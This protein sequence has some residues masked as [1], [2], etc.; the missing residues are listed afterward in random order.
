MGAVEPK[1]FLAA[2]KY[3]CVIS[4]IIAFAKSKAISDIVKIHVTMQTLSDQMQ[5]QYSLILKLKNSLQHVHN[6]FKLFKI[7]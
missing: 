6:N 2:L 4:Q 3:A 5:N 7:F 1:L